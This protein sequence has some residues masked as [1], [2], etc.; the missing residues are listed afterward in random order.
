MIIGGGVTIGTVCLW[1]CSSG[2]GK[3]MQKPSIATGNNLVKRIECLLS[4]VLSYFSQHSIFIIKML[5]VAIDGFSLF[6]PAPPE[7]G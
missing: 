2:T 1:P 4:E 6:F 5:L 3:K 7:H